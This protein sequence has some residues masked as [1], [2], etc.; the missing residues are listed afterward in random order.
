[1]SRTSRRDVLEVAASQ[2]G[3]FSARQARSTGLTPRMLQHWAISGEITSLERGVWGISGA[4]DSLERR[5]LAVVLSHGHGAALCRSS[6]AWLWKLPGRRLEP[7][8][9]IRQRDE[10]LPSTA[11]S[12]TSRL[13]EGTDVTVRRG[14]PVTTPVRTVFDLA[15]RQ[16]PERT[17]KDLNDLMARGLVTT[18]ILDEALDRLAARGRTGIRTMRELIAEV[19]EKGVPAGSALELVV[20]DLLDTAGYRHM[21]RQ[22]PV[23][24]RH[25][26]IARL[27]FGDRRRR[28]AIEVDSDRFHHGLIDRQLDRR[29][30][31]RLEACGWT[32]VRIAEPEIWHERSAL[33]S[34]LRN[35]MWRCPPI[36]D[37]DAA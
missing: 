31:V 33:V 37:D 19:H 14:I 12:R 2:Y 34:R 25:G 35:V 13:L 23:H 17:R 24:D 4:P 32:V 15:G 36:L 16:H 8:V 22:V 7:I 3:L 1:M 30:T 6:A 26:F 21:E 11:S 5:A 10:H 9:V 29:K 27:D 18:A 28:I 20:E